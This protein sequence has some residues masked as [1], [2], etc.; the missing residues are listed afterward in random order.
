MRARVKADCNIST[1]RSAGM[2]FVRMQWSDVPEWAEKEISACEFLEV[3]KPAPEPEP[4]EQP[5]TPADKAV[6]LVDVRQGR[7]KGKRKL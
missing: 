6:K 3:E 7:A 5:R 4:S 2:I 1:V